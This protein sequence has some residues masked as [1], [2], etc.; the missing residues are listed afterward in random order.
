MAVAEHL[1]HSPQPLMKNIQAVLIPGG[2]LIFEVP[3][4]A[5]WSRRFS[6]FFPGRTVFAPIA[7]LYHSAIP[8]TGHHREYTLDDVRYVLTESGYRIVGE[9]LFNYGLDN[10]GVFRQLYMLPARIFP[11]CAGVIFSHRVNP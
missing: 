6:F 11:R 8:F 7:Q 1:A 3:N 5:F 2:H 9:E 4:L 10:L